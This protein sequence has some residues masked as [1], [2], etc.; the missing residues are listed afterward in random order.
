MGACWEAILVN[1]WRMSNNEILKKNFRF[2]VEELIRNIFWNIQ[3][4]LQIETLSK[5]NF[6]RQLSDYVKI[7]V[8]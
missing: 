4:G 6:Y 8:P 1:D 5:Y 2:P 3:E 7:F